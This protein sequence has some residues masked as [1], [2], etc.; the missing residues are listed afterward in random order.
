VSSGLGVSLEAGPKAEA[1]WVR[2]GRARE[3]LGRPRR[4]DQRV[5][6]NRL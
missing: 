1:A 5:W 2:A 3:I 6:M 4:F